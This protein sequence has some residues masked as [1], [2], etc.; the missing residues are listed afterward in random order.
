MYFKVYGY[1]T[2]NDQM[3]DI[4]YI[5]M[6]LSSS[7]KILILAAGGISIGAGIAYLFYML[8]KDSDNDDGGHAGVTDKNIEDLY[9]SKL[10]IVSSLIDRDF[11]NGGILQ[12]D[13][14]ASIYE[15]LVLRTKA[16]YQA[17]LWRSR[18]QRRKVLDVDMEEYERIA[19]DTS[20]QIERMIEDNMHEILE[21]LELPPELFEESNAYWSKMN[22]NF[23]ILGV[24]MLGEMRET[25]PPGPEV[26]LVTRELVKEIIQYQLEEVR[27]IG[28][29]AKDPKNLSLVKQTI[30]AD[31]VNSKYKI[32][33]EDLSRDISI[34]QDAELQ[35]AIKKMQQIIQQEAQQQ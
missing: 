5:L 27:K 7:N 33:E 22:P 24:V 10:S 26:P 9:D 20:D 19:S 30:L 2:Q 18:Q 25:M 13:T 4:Y 17:L 31:R 34:K 15:V 3:Y 32:E 21:R 12:R 8:G 6:K 29:Q 11:E 1:Y 16:E 14:I 23:A 35:F 28:Y